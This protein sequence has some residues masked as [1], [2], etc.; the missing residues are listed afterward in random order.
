MAIASPGARSADEL[1]R[2]ADMAMY[3]VKN[4]RKSQ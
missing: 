4:R 3:R 1:L 2:R